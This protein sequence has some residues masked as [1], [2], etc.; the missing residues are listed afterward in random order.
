[1]S[2]TNEPKWATMVPL[3]GGSAFGCYKATGTKP[4]YNMSY[5][6]FAANESFFYRHWDEIPVFLIDEGADPK[7]SYPEQLGFVN[8]VCPCA[9]L[10]QLSTAKAGSYQRDSMNK[11]MF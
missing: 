4:L 7:E 10:S 2:E 1:M 8:S 9:G 3:I 6:P 5:T 11:W